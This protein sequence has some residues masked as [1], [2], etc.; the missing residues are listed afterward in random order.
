MN[1]YYKEDDD[2]ELVQIKINDDV[3]RAKSCHS[4]LKALYRKYLL[5]RE[6]IRGTLYTVTGQGDPV[7]F[8][9]YDSS[10]KKIIIWDRAARFA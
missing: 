8:G 10:T 5:L 3:W 9:L 1:N 2:D 4:E 6:K 7:S